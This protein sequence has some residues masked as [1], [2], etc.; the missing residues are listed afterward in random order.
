[1]DLLLS[2][3][4]LCRNYIITSFVFYN[5]INVLFLNSKIAEKYFHSRS[6]CLFIV[7]TLQILDAVIHIQGKW[8]AYVCVSS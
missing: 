2:H 8:L 6:L 5:Y 3:G 7:V 4:A 1:M